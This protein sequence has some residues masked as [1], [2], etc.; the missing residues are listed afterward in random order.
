M[1]NNTRKITAEKIQSVYPRLS[2]LL[3]PTR[4]QI[5][6]K[7]LMV[8]KVLSLTGERRGQYFFYVN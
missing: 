1:E 3:F 4:Q 7:G 2:L 6:G 8:E 5:F